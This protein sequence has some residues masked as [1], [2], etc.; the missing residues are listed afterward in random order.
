M[1]LLNLIIR[2]QIAEQILKGVSI[3]RI[4]SQLQLGKSTVYF[5]YKKKLMGKNIDVNITFSEIE[6]EIVGVFSG[7]GSQYVEPKS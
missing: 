2:K 6:D 4:C 5:Y 3:N 1:V 7:D